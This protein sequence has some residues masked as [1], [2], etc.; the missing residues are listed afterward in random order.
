MKNNENNFLKYN[1]LKIK[2]HP[3]V[4]EPAEDTYLLVDSFDIKKDEKILEI[5]TGT[6]LIALN[7]AKKGANVICTDINPY[8][9]EITNKNIEINK[10][11][12][13][14]S[15][16]VIYSDLFSNI[17][18]KEIFD[19]IIF[20]PPYLPTSKDEIVGGS[21]WFDKAVDGGK[22]GLNVTKRF[23]EEINGHL[24]KDGSVFLIYSSLSDRNTLEKIIRDNVFSYDIVNKCFF[25]TEKIFVYRLYYNNKE[26]IKDW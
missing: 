17:K 9:L 18:N 19:I 14:G 4:Y 3:E 1:D 22:T 13:K 20:N 6:G 12:I 5:G 15:I 10:N 16:E 2:L 7:C 25:E 11:I 8:S 24:K 21:G 26:K 23:I